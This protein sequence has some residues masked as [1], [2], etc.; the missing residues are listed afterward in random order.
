MPPG[1]EG[2]SFPERIDWFQ[3]QSEDQIECTITLNNIVCF[4]EF[5]QGWKSGMMKKMQKM[6]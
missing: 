2:V 4:S 3:L 5:K 1:P 6:L